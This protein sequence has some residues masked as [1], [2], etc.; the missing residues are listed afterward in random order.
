MLY[1]FLII[2][3]ILLVI[4]FF[5][6]E[7]IKTNEKNEDLELFSTDE[8]ESRNNIKSAKC[9]QCGKIATTYDDVKEYFGLRQV[10]YSTDIQS[11]CRECR[12]NR[13]NEDKEQNLSE[14]DL[15]LFDE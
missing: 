13:E 12:K 8:F 11:W 3:I 1:L 9:P 6:I 4:V 2:V 15:S 14:E 5:A 10:G 7:N